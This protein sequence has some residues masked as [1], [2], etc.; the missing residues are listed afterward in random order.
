MAALI[1]PNFWR[2]TDTQMFVG[3]RPYWRKWKRYKNVQI[4]LTP[5]HKISAT[6]RHFSQNPQLLKGI[7][8]RHYTVFQPQLWRNIE[9]GACKYTYDFMRC[10]LSPRRFSQNLHL[11]DNILQ[12]TWRRIPVESYKSFFRWYSI[13][14]ERMLG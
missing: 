11:L 7:N 13:G 8:R 9:S 14:D 12:R 5:S 2:L 6:I 1:A 3:R 4:S 10:V